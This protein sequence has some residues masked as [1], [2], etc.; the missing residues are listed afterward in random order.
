MKPQPPAPLE[1]SHKI[2][3]RRREKQLSQAELAQHCG[4][5]RQFIN[6]VEA[7]KT[8]PNVQVALRL[9][10]ALECLVEDLFGSDKSANDATLALRLTD[11]NLVDGARL[12]IARVSGR[13]IGHAAD[14]IQSFGG[15]FADADALLTRVGEKVSARVNRTANELEQNIAIA[16]CDPALAL[17]QGNVP[18]LAGRCFWVN[19]G[20]ARALE[21]LA[22]GWVHAAGLHY[23]GADGKENL[24]HIERF[25]AAGRWQVLRFT[26]WEQ[27]WM[28]RPGIQNKF[29]DATDL[30]SR[31]IRLANREPGSGSRHWLDAQIAEIGVSD[32]RIR[33][34]GQEYKSHWEC[35]RTLVEGQADVAVGPRAVAT[36]FGLEFLPVMEVAFD[37][38]IPRTLLDHPRIQAILQRIRSRGFRREI[39]MLP[40]YQA[41]EA[42]TVLERVSV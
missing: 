35:A 24:R 12:R 20:S 41:P 30:S 9:A 31:D 32:K 14:T 25:D 16:G 26:R 3:T 19:C 21:L 13:W 5:S 18:G 27:G 22:G 37:L 4:L 6:M 17:L 36:V 1:G 8:Q 23:S 33:G 11:P 38:V 15:G 39:E 40:G 10:E 34:Y 28:L 29:H 7:G 42:G 2:A